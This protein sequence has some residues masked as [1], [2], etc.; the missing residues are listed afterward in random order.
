M[1]KRSA[2]TDTLPGVGTTKPGVL[3]HLDPEFIQRVDDFRYQHRFPSRA[4][5]MRFLMEWALNLAD[6]GSEAMDHLKPP[7]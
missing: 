7:R 5:A 3:I 2:S 1:T 6:S 4:A